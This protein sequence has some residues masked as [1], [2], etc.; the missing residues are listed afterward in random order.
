MGFLQL[1]A[2]ETLN[3]VR[4]GDLGAIPDHGGGDLRIEKWLRDLSGMD[5]KEI[6]IL[7]SR[8]HDLF[9]LRVTDELPEDVERS[10]RLHGGK[11]DDSS[12]G[13]SGDLD[14]FEPRDKGVFPDEFRIQCQSR[15][16]P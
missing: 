16:L 8:M 3:Q 7:P 11:I 10:A 6:E 5:G 9:N 4:I 14:Q 2:V 12:S 15:T 1:R 13:G